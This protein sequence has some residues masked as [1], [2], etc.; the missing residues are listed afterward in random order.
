[1]S[2]TTTKSHNVALV[3]TIS[4]RE[5]QVV[6]GALRT[7]YDIVR[8]GAHGDTLPDFDAMGVEEYGKVFVRAFRAVESAHKA[9]REAKAQAFR[10]QI[11]G[12]IDTHIARHS[13]EVSQLRA[14]LDAMSPALRQIVM[15]S[16]KV[17]DPH[18][19]K[20]PMS[21]I[22]AQFKQ[23]TP[24]TDILRKLNTFGYKVVGKDDKSYIKVDLSSNGAK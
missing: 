23:G 22:I 5:E 4:D 19:V 12:V 14:E 7:L 16:G 17:P 11:Q 18:T 21:D 6:M 3:S 10:Q 9:R 20:V 8:G 15:S 2:N 1:M 13:A 24:V